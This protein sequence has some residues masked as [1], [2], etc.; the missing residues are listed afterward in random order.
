MS[1]KSATG[2]CQ[3]LSTMGLLDDLIFKAIHETKPHWVIEVGNKSPVSILYH[4]YLLSQLGETSHTLVSITGNLKEMPQRRNIYYI[5]EA[6]HFDVRGHLE[7]LIHPG[8]RVMVVLGDAAGQPNPLIAIQIYAP[9]VTE[10]CH[11][12]LDETI[13]RFALN[14]VEFQ[15]DWKRHEPQVYI[16]ASG[17]DGSRHSPPLRFD[18][19]QQTPAALQF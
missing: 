18:N 3:D 16:R 7:K 4:G 13:G 14:H 8:E 11:L 2:V 5:D 19:T 15:P 9:L 17:R 1:T 10:G 6:I 12:I